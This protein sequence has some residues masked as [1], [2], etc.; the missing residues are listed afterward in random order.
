MKRIFLSEFL[1]CG[2][3]LVFCA[4]LNVST[5][6]IILGSLIG[7]VL[8]A[9]ALLAV[10]YLGLPE[11]RV[12]IVLIIFGGLAGGVLQTRQRR[13]ALRPY[14]AR[15]CMGFR[16][17]RRFPDAPKAEIREFLNAF[18]DAFMLRRKRRSFF[19]PDDRVMALYRAL[20]PPGS[21]ADS[22]ELETLC[23]ALKTSY[24]VDFVASWRDDITLGEMYEQ[25]HRLR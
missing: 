16:W 17:R 3:V 21:L 11:K 18:V 4:H 1:L 12:P 7:A 24:G 6:R 15:G 19:S 22:M 2:Y 25:T 9:G 23:K 10:W 14:W 8:L 5:R 20:N 13:A